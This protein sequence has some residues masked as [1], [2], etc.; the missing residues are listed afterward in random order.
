MLTSVFLCKPL[1]QRPKATSRRTWRCTAAP[2][3]SRLRSAEPRRCCMR[4]A[5]TGSSRTTTRA[6]CCSPGTSS[7]SQVSGQTAGA[8]LAMLLGACMCHWQEDAHACAAGTHPSI[9]SCPC[10]RTRA[11]TAAARG[12]LPRHTRRVRRVFYQAARQR[13][14]Q[15]PVGG[16]VDERQFGARGPPA[17]HRGHG[18][19]VAAA[20]VSK[21]ACLAHRARPCMRC[22]VAESHAVLCRSSA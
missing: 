4:A 8:V 6:R 21:Y 3:T 18:A 1:L 19:A 14:R 5:A 7:A 9:A 13:G 15:R 2:R 11:H 20:S 10:R 12:L 22:I 17:Q 16:R